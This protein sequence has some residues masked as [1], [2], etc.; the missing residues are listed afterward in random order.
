MGSEEVVRQ[1]SKGLRDAMVELDR[2]RAEGHPYDLSVRDI[3]E[4]GSQY[5]KIICKI[6]HNCLFHAGFRLK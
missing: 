2:E 4:N 3:L 6:L 1:I 5:N